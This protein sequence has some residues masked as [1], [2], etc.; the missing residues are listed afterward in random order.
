MDEFTK[1]IQ[2]VYDMIEVF[3]VTDNVNADMTDEVIDFIEKIR[4]DYFKKGYI[5]ACLIENKQKL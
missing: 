4:F 1:K 3:K 5:S 2:E